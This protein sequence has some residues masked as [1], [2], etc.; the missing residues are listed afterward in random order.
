MV[1]AGLYLLYEGCTQHGLPREFTNWPTIYV[2]LSRWAKAGMLER[3]AARLQRE[4]LGGV[5][6]DTL[7]LRS[8]II[9]VH[10]HGTDALRRRGARQSAV[11]A[12]V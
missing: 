9:K 4:A 11:Q 1:E 2:C 8:T 3:L 7:A 5:G 6:L 10:G 12:A